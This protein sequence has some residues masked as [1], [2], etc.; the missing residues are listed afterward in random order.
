M[1]TRDIDPEP[2]LIV[3][4]ENGEISRKLIHVRNAREY[5]VI[6]ERHEIYTEGEWNEEEGGHRWFRLIS[7]ESVRKKRL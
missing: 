4:R 2:Y 6:L 1:R 5:T 7:E 3:Q